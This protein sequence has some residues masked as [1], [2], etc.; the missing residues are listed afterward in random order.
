MLRRELTSALAELTSQ[1]KGRLPGELVAVNA[2]FRG[3]NGHP[4][5]NSTP[6]SFNVNL[7]FLRG[8]RQPSL[9]LSR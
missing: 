2:C 5:W 7:T 3:S 9:C 6:L 8:S 4:S 1:K